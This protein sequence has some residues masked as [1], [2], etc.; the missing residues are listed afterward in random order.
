MTVPLQSFPPALFP[1]E[2][3]DVYMSDGRYPVAD[4]WAAA[5]YISPRTAGVVVTVNATTSGDQ[6]VFAVAPAVTANWQPGDYAWEVWATL[7]DA[8]HRV[9]GGALLVR[10][11][12]KGQ[13]FAIDTRTDAER[14]LA[15][16]RAAFAAWSPLTKQY[17]IGS[18]QMTF[19]SVT[20]IITA[21][22]YWEGAVRR[23]RMAQAILDGKPT[24]R[25][26]YVRMGRA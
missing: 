4:S 12:L 24:G 2:S 26:V 1:G 11:A 21:I 7:G 20:E 10:T 19:Q 16:Y 15:D 22:Q 6:H 9:A 3:L 8:A 23:E 13:D 17:L 5:L 25:K 18:R 14:T